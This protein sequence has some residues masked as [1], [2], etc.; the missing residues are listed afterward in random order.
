LSESVDML[1]IRMTP[2]PL[3]KYIESGGSIG[4]G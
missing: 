1:E 2:R 4:R 3:L